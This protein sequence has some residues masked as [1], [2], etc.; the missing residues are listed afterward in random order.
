M[1]PRNAVMFGPPGH[2]YVYFTY[3]NHWMLNI[4]A[5]DDGDAAAVL[6]RAAIPL[7]GLDV[8]RERRFRTQKLQSDANLLSGPG[9]I[10]QA[11]GIDRRHNGID[12]LDP[13]GELWL[14]PGAPVE[15][16][17]VGTRI[18]LAIGMGDDLPWRFLDAENLRWASK[19]LPKV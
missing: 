19:P 13:S 9:K 3:G 17:T 7:E 18:G 8:M 1:T 10:C 15:R 12:L 2:A 16:V 14:E 4:T 5:H 11:F 6:I